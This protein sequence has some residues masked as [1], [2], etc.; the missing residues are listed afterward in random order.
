VRR[1]DVDMDEIVRAI[2]TRN[3]GGGDNDE[4]DDIGSD[5]TEP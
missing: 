3:G 2:T 4:R 1:R 5:D